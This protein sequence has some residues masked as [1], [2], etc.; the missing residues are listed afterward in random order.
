M[1]SD[2]GD[3]GETPKMDWEMEMGTDTGR[4]DGH[5]SH[6]DRHGSNKPRRR[7]VSRS[8][9]T[10][11]VAAMLIAVGIGVA[12]AGASSSSSIEQVWSFG[13]GQIAIKETSPGTLTGTVVAPTTFAECVHPVGQQIWTG[14]TLQP[15]GSYWGFHQWYERYPACQLD[16]TLG[17]TAWRVLTGANG[18]LYLRVCLSDPDN[19]SQPT[20]AANGTYSGVTYGCVDSALTAPLPGSGVAGSKES[21]TILPSNKQCL[22]RRL[23]QIHLLEPQYD[24]LKTVSITIKGRKIASVHK[25]HYIVATINLRG[26]PKGAFTIKVKAITVLGNHLSDSRTY[27]TCVKKKNKPRNKLKLSKEKA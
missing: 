17:K 4:P 11:L 18:S 3:Q 14:M 23:F 8:L 26:L 5:G 16:P 7:R 9:S 2:E 24:P 21:L 25:G 22:S 15:D 19:N 1:S 27:H 20:I 10:G 13:G 6:I 12:S